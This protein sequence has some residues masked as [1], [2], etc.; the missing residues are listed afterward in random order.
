MHNSDF[1][2]KAVAFKRCPRFLFYFAAFGLAHI[3]RSE[4]T[5]I[6]GDNYESISYDV[7]E[8]FDRMVQSKQKYYVTLYDINS[9][10]IC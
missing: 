4:L 3:F 6:D 1:E 10:I 5:E 2:L 8:F 9:M 7:T